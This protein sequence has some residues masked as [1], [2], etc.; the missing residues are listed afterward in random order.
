MDF[1]VQ[2]IFETKAAGRNDQKPQMMSSWQTEMELEA[3]I[4]EE[5]TWPRPS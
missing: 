3:V 5:E 2:H 4:A 1:V